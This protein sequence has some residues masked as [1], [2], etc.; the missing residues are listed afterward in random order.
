MA[1]SSSSPPAKRYLEFQDSTHSA[2]W[3]LSP[4]EV[5]EAD[6]RHSF[7]AD[8]VDVFKAKLL[9]TQYLTAL[10]RRARVRQRAVATAIVYFRRFYYKYSFLEHDPLL[11]APT[12]LWVASKVE[13]CSMQAKMLVGHLAHLDMENSYQVHHLLDAEFHL[14]EALRFDLVVYQPYL[15]LT[16]Y[17]AHPALCEIIEAS[18][19]ENFRQTA[20]FLLN[21]CFRTDLVLCHPPHTIAQACIHMAG[22]LLGL[23]SSKWLYRIDIDT[24]QVEE[25]TMTLVRMYDYCSTMADRELQEVHA[26]LTS[27]QWGARRPPRRAN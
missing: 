5:A 1:S 2:H 25:V 24:Q 22:T 3:L 14:I 10:G 12:A 20:W 18:S 11:I 23:P 21:D 26:E 13:E 7:S 19:H 8:P 17:L 4:A 15:P 16:E 9:Y 6:M 27:I